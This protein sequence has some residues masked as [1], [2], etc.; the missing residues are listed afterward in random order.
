MEK[1]VQHNRNA[2]PFEIIV[3]NAAH[4]MGNAP[5]KITSRHLNCITLFSAL[6]EMRNKPARYTE[7]NFGPFIIQPSYR[8]LQITIQSSIILAPYSC[9]LNGHYSPTG[10]LM[11]TLFDRQIF[12]FLPLAHTRC[13]VYPFLSLPHVA[14]RLI[15]L[16]LKA[17]DI[18]FRRPT[19][20]R[21]SAI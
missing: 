14:P 1:K 7:R 16:F 11:Q 10:I 8:F 18:R 9:W 20:I 6:P 4:S 15:S 5:Y 3:D 13:R 19:S 17:K 21:C 2:F 12:S